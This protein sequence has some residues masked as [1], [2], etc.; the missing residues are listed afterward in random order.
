MSTPR[1]TTIGSHRPRRLWLPHGITAATAAARPLVAH[2]PPCRRPGRGG[3]AVDRASAWRR[4]GREAAVTAPP[5][6]SMPLRRPDHYRAAV[7]ESA[8]ASRYR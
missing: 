7:R 4:C 3:A 2:R 8:T 5:P 6:V 1:T